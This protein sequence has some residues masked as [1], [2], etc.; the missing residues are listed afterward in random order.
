MA[1]A[2]VLI[3]NPGSA[4]RKYALF[5]DEVLRASIEFE[6]VNGIVECTLRTKTTQRV[7]VKVR[8]LTHAAHLV[9]D[10]LRSHRVLH[11]HEQLAAIGLRI[12]APGDYFLHDHLAGE[13]FM[14]RLTQ[15]QSLA[16]LHIAA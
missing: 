13:E 15:A 5:E 6:W 12:V 1:G 10:I 11:R 14:Q 2:L 9:L 7:V 8:E 4:S 16:P 3:A